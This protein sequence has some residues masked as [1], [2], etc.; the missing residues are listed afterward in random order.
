MASGALPE[1]LGFTGNAVLVTQ[2]HQLVPAFV[3]ALSQP[4]DMKN[5]ESQQQ[6]VRDRYSLSRI[7][8]YWDELLLADADRFFDLA[9]PWQYSKNSRY[10]VKKILAHFHAGWLLDRFLELRTRLQK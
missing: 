7:V 6:Q 2:P 8:E 4:N 3:D 9:G 5:I 1:T 10:V